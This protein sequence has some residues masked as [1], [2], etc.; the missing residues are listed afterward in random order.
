MEGRIKAQERKEKLDFLR[1]IDSGFVPVVYDWACGEELDYIASTYPQHSAGDFVRCM[2]QVLD[3]LRQI[4]EVVREP[5]L[6]GLVSEAMDDVHRSIVAYTSV[7]DA[8][9]EEL[10]HEPASQEEVD[11]EE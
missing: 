7:V 9:E 2:K 3:I 11:V 5:H 10:E 6:S 1:P 8:M 4:K